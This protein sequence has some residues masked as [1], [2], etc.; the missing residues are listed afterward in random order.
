MRSDSG[1]RRFWRWISVCLLL[2]GTALLAGCGDSSPPAQRPPSALPVNVIT[3]RMMTVPIY[4]EAVGNTQALE[5]VEIRSRVN[6]HLLRRDFDDGALVKKDQL[7]FLIDPEQYQ[8][9]LAKAK[10]QH[11]YAKVS[12]ELAR[13]ETQRYATL[14]R[15]AMISQEE[16]DLK[17]IKEQEAEASVLVS[18]A[19]VNLAELQLRYTRINSPI[20]GRIGFALVDQGGLVSA[21]T[22]L[23][24]RVSTVDPMHLFFYLSEEDYLNL[25]DH[26]GDDFE[27]VIKTLDIQLTLAGG[28]IYQHIGH[29]DMFDREVD[30]KTGSI[31]ARA[32][33]PNPDGMLRPGMFGRVRVTLE[34]EWETLLIP[35]VAIMD[36]LGRKSV[37]VVDDQ[38]LVASR[39]VEVGMRLNNL[40][41]VRGVE[42]GDRVVVDNLQKLRPGAHVAPTVISYELEDSETTLTAPVGT[43]V[44]DP[45]DTSVSSPS[46]DTSPSLPSSDTS[47]ASASREETSEETEGALG[48]PSDGH[49]G[50]TSDAATGQ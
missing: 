14:L 33:F 22:T 1:A 16:F 37:F 11:E 34:Q 12:L 9:D 2:G 7:L 41:A 13:K 43:P 25:S 29:L 32:V 5:T 3:A 47:P 10:A 44:S 15:Q 42:P 4:G 8:Q 6:G 24:A 27:D 48:T 46:A 39:G 38:G 45:T 36:T 30:P 49:P 20:D 35:Q 21:G 26:F 50:D 17:E 19:S 28:L 40:R 31:A 18:A 23:L